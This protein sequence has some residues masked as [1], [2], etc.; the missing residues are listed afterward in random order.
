MGNSWQN[1]PLDFYDEAAISAIS[2]IAS[3]KVDA[4]ALG[5][6]GDGRFG[7]L[8]GQGAHRYAVR[9]REGTQHEISPRQAEMIAHSCITPIARTRM[10][11]IQ[12]TLMG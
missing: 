12:P 4:A 6:I 9:P 2:N 7:D 1:R 11:F 5:A 3:E 10:K 8:K